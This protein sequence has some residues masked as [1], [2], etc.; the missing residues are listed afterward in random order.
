MIIKDIIE[1][2]ER[3]RPG[4]GVTL[5]DY[6]DTLNLLEEDIHTNI[7][8]AHDGAQEFVAHTSEEDALIVPDM[9]ADLYSFWVFAR[10]D[11]AN[12]DVGGYTNNM[13]LFNNLVNE[14]SRYYTRTHMPRRK[15]RIRWR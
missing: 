8:S 1:R 11:L 15:G 4:C 3:Q 14:Y 10:L 7:V 2:V 9:Y 13:I 5:K 6:I 12:E